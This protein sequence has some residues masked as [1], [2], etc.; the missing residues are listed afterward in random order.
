VPYEEEEVEFEEGRELPL[1]VDD[2]ALV[3]EEQLRPIRSGLGSS[4]GNTV[5]EAASAEAATETTDSPGFNHEVHEVA[6]S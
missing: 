2:P 5:A 3:T 6:Q 1:G 4:G